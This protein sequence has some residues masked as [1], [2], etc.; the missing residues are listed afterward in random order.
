MGQITRCPSC[1]TLFKVVPDQL[2]ISD[3]WVRC[4]H[5]AEVFDARL[6][7]QNDLSAPPAMATIEPQSQAVAASEY[8]PG[9]DASSQAPKPF[10]GLQDH[11]TAQVQ[12]EPSEAAILVQTS[13][14]AK[15]ESPAEEV[16]IAGDA[17][18]LSFLRGSRSTAFWQH[19]GV[20]LI[21][22]SLAAFLLLG[23][24]AQWAVDQRDRLA[25][26]WPQTKPWLEAACLPLACKVQA[27]R[28]I[29]NLVIDGS[30]FNKQ[31]P[32]LFRLSFVLRNG[33]ALEAALPAV[34]LTLTNAQ[35][36]AV[37][38]RVLRPAE[39]GAQV[40]SI[41]PGAEW[42]ANVLVQLSL[43]SAEVAGYRILAFYP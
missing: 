42:S 25:T 21:L 19:P 13:Q 14:E 16:I 24:L 7:M 12:P 2:K 17:R 33:G 4:G 27:M 18:D 28:Q 36:Q 35:D 26:L 5:C 10:I 38:R 9:Q 43:S 23:L 31:A 8:D 20:R 40:G 34:E 37:L 32:N 3:G 39:L 6:H 1:G 15:A 22:A 30:S 41:K 29:D 11:S